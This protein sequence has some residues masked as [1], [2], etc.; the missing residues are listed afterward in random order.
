MSLAG[1]VYS[2][3]VVAAPNEARANLGLN[4]QL[5]YKLNPSKG[6]AGCVSIVWLKIESLAFE[7]DH[8]SYFHYYL[9]LIQKILRRR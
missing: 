2:Q 7:V 1:V 4:H 6:S 5:N 3:L 8:N 9:V